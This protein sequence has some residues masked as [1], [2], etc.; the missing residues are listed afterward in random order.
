MNLNGIGC[1]VGRVAVEAHTFRQTNAGTGE[2]A[3]GS[4]DFGAAQ[5]NLKGFRGAYGK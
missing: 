4:G 2:G 5:G 1:V 3:V